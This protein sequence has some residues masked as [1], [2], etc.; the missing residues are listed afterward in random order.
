LQRYSAGHA[1]VVDEHGGGDEWV[2]ED[3]HLGLG[4]LAVPADQFTGV[5]PEYPEEA[6]GTG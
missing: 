6:A 1:N 5:Q 2:A 3:I 4:R